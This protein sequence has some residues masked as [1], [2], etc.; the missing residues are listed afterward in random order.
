[1]ANVT[2][3]WVLPTQRTDGKA[4]SPSEIANVEITFGI[5][6]LPATSVGKFPPATLT[7]SLQDVEAG[8][9]IASAFVTDTQN[10]PEISAGVHVPVSIA[11]PRFAAPSD[12]TLTFSLS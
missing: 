9:Y 12:V 5:A 4:L 10:P 8:D 2:F 3:N 11:A 6:G 7:A 1:M